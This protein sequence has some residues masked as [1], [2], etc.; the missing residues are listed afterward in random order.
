[1]LRLV[2]KGYSA[3]IMDISVTTKPIVLGRGEG[4][5]HLLKDSSVSLNH[6]K[7]IMRQG[8]VYIRDLESTNGVFVNGE[9]I[10]I[11][12][13]QVISPGDEIKIGIYSFS[14]E[15]YNQDKDIAKTMLMPGI[16]EAPG[17]KLLHKGDSGKE[18]EF[19]VTNRPISVGRGEGNMILL[20]DPGVS[21]NHAKIM[22]RKNN[23][24]V[25]DLESTNGVFVNG[26]IISA[27]R[28]QIVYP[29]DEI[30]IG[31]SLFAL[32]RYSEE[33]GAENTMLIAPE[34]ADRSEEELTETNVLHME[35]ESDRKKD[36]RAKPC[37]EADESKEVS[38]REGGTLMMGMDKSALQVSKLVIT[39]GID[40]G[41]EFL[42]KDE[43][44]IGRSEDNDIILQDPTV[45]RGRHAKVVRHKDD[46]VTITDL[47]S[48]NGVFVGGKRIREAILV[49]G[50]EI[51]IGETFLRYVDR[52][53]IISL[54]ERKSQLLQVL[55]KIPRNVIIAI[56]A[57]F[58]ILVLLLAVSGK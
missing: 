32:E 25:K 12:K 28:G 57:L 50:A 3:T 18:M 45:S 39:S 30:K 36:V 33:E 23:V 52:G 43:L 31:T 13:S 38:E 16:S 1:M 44:I 10:S 58:G 41:K 46:W 49:R 6:A 51:K 11:I 20:S 53:E 26:V 47:N 56:F 5:T 34:P 37:A 22:M 55:N 42:L 7:I 17:F 48:A 4:S 19:S 24:Y 15:E 2:L 27:K 29:G 9:K 54:G 8:K 14:L 21:M 40:T 35:K